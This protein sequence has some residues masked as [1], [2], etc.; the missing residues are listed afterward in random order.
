LIPAHYSIDIYDAHGCAVNTS[1]DISQPTP[2]ELALT[3]DSLICFGAETTLQATA[4]GGFGSKTYHWN[5]IA[6]VSGNSI[7]SPQTDTQYTVY[8]TDAN[9]CVSDELTLTVFVMSMDAGLLS[10]SEDTSICPAEYASLSGYY[11]GNYPPYTYSW[12]NG[13]GLGAGPHNVSPS[14]T[15]T[16]ELTV[17]DVCDN[18]LTA[19]VVVDIFEAPVALLPDDL[20]A[21]CSPLEI[22]LSDPFNVGSGF[23]HEWLITN[24]ESY[25]GNPVNFSLTDPGIYEISLLVTSPDGCTASSHIG[26]PVDV[27]ELPVANFSASPWTTS[28]ENPEIQFTDISTGAIS[29]IWTIDNSTIQNQYQTAYTFADT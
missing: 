24:G 16:Y 5:H 23:T 3:G 19:N 22:N 6:S 26:I 27:Y 7:V 11:S 4:T 1:F 17:T 14:E 29:T 25:I 2:L 15:T 8:A 28:I 9:G 13:P 12:T 18:A 20:L 10:I 21:G